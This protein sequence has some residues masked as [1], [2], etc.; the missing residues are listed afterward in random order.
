MRRTKR[1][2]GYRSGDFLRQCDRSG[3]TVLA[4][5]TR[6]EWTGLIVREDL[7]EPRH[8]QDFVRAQADDMAVREGRPEK[9]PESA[10][11][12][13]L[14]DIAAVSGSVVGGTYTSGAVTANRPFVFW[15]LDLEDTF[16][17]SS[18]SLA[19][20]R[21]TENPPEELARGL[22]IE[23]QT[24]DQD[25][26]TGT[27]SRTKLPLGYPEATRSAP[28]DAAIA[29]YAEARRLRLVLA[30]STPQPFSGSLSH[31][32]ISLRRTTRMFN[33]EWEGG[34]PNNQGVPFS[35]EVLWS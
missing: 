26:N 20:L 30:G 31:G 11:A 24:F 1:P 33:R 5:N 23:F 8:P 34:T 25:V 21:W 32:A 16:D 35:N 29:F 12:R 10:L 27:W 22:Y 18:V 9:K 13:S 19:G 15:T 28:E 7:W 6:K 3:Q 17:V 4:S 2:Q 14:A